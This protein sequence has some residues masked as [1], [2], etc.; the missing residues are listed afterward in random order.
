MGKNKENIEKSMIG[1][2]PISDELDEKCPLKWF[3]VVLFTSKHEVIEMMK[4]SSM[5][6]NICRIINDID[7]KSLFK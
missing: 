2:E 4:R 6:C 1:R 5:H 7:M 3:Q